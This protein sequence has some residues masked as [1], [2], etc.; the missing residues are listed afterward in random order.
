[1][2]ISLPQRTVFF[3]KPDAIDTPKYE[4]P[5]AYDE[6]PPTITASRN[7]SHSSKMTV[8]SFTS[9]YFKR[10]EPTIIST[11]SNNK[12]FAEVVSSP[13]TS[14]VVKK[15]PVTTFILSQPT[16]TTQTNF[17]HHHEEEYNSLKNNIVYNFKKASIDKPNQH[18]I[19]LHIDHPD[20]ED[21][22]V[23]VY[24]KV[25]P[26]SYTWGFQSMLYSNRN[27]GQGIKVAEARRRAFQ[28]DINTYAT[29]NIHSQ[30][31][32]KR[33][34]S[35][36]LFDDSDND[37]DDHDNHTH[38]N[39]RRWKLLAEFDSGTM[40]YLSKE[41][42]K[43]SIDLD[44]LNQVEKD[45]CDLLEANIVMTC[46]TLI[47]IMYLIC[48]VL[49][50]AIFALLSAAPP[51]LPLY[52]HDVLGF[53]SDQI[54][55]VLAIAP[56]IQSIACPLWT[57]TVDKRPAL[58]GPIMAI[59]SLIGGSAIMTIMVI[60]NSV[61]SDIVNPT[62]IFSTLKLQL[63]N[64]SLVLV[65]SALALT[66]AFF[67][68]PNLSLVD[69]AV[70]KILGPNKIL[71]GKQR[72][73]GSVSA[74]ATILIVG[75]II[76]MTGSL[77]GLF[78]VFGA[79]TLL[80]IVFSCFVNVSH[81]SSEYEHLPQ[82][83]DED[84]GLERVPSDGR[85]L[86]QVMTDTSEKLLSSEGNSHYVDLFKP[87]ST[88]S[89]HT[90]R[91]EADET[92]EAIGGLNLGLAISRIASVDQ[93][94]IH[95]DSEGIPPSSMFKSVRVVTFLITTLLFGFVL[96]M[97]LTEIFGVTNMILIAHVATIVRCL[98]YTVLTPDSFF[99][100]VSALSL[101]TLHGIGFGIF[102]ATSVSEMDGFFPPEQR[103][104][105][106]G[107]LGALHFGLG[108]GLGALSGGY[109]Y[110]YM[111]AIWMFRIGALVATINMVIFY[112]GRLDR[113]NK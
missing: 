83:A 48:K 5:N 91:E 14:P 16:L 30:D 57:Y 74:G 60:G 37:E 44:I 61:S 63:S 107:I 50:I 89:A 11:L 71:Y 112:V 24:R 69:S 95:I 109:L 18:H 43:L 45:R 25:Q 110:E 102:W 28:K 62:Q 87:N 64:S 67:T 56:F 6:D 32:I 15:E 51:Y 4:K 82:N 97:I 72:L 53:S 19:F 7:G 22:E 96:S 40:N 23:M 35:N 39:C 59:T 111:G 101:Q 79:S 52:Y 31:L 113:F 34:Q 99:T 84:A 20:E 78:W 85:L 92:L 68:L 98:I 9:R 36:I 27:D 17:G 94:M 73:W 38:K 26:Y 70:M 12:G 47:V 3:Q 8:D 108:A 104:V 42:G 76:S 13:P 93:P 103:S 21:E 2:N 75:Q 41:Y 106:Q 105:A 77:D 86:S 55:F 1:M 29:S 65:T 46:C 33:S 80:F 66:F 10:R 90:I 100:N 58:H 49:Y 88:T 54:G 81:S